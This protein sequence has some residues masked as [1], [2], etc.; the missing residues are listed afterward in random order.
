MVEQIAVFK[1]GLISKPKQDA[2]LKVDDEKQSDQEN[3]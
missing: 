2:S 3:D 1:R